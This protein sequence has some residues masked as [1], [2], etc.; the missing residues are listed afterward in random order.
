MPTL[1]IVAGVVGIFILLILIAIHLYV[2]VKPNQAHVIV[3]A[4][5]RRVYSPSSIAMGTG[6]KKSYPTSYFFIPFLM[7][8]II[9]SLENVKHEINQVELRDTN[10]APFKCDITC[11]FKIANPD[12]AAEKLDVDAQGNI[13]ESIRQTLDASVMGITRAAAMGQEVIALM[14]DRKTFG[15]KVFTEVNGDLDEWGVQLVKLE[16]IDFSDAS[17]SQVIKDHEAR[18][19]AEIASTTRQEVAEQTKKAE[20]VEAEARKVAE[21]AKLASKEDIEMREIKKNESVGIRKE[22]SRLKIEEQTDKANA[23]KVA[24]DRTLMVGEAEYQADALEIVAEGKAK[25]LIK[26]AHGNKEARITTAT[27]EANAV[28]LNADA[29]AEAV[30]KNGNAEASVHETKGTADAEVIRQRGLATAEALEKKADAQKKFTEAS[31]EIEFKKIDAEV[32]IAKYASQAEAYKN[33]DIQIVSDD[34][35]FLGFDA[36]SGVGLGLALDN[37]KKTSKLD[38]S[39]AVSNIATVATELLGKKGK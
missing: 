6:E 39:K 3:D 11:W 18:R 15:E 33:A 27:G 19:E 7:E 34:M 8:R 13:M 35:N 31:Q 10:V 4:R 21:T 25:A 29:Q 9:V 1:F 12:L 14:R 24:A 16:I 20:V 32:E 5:G 28:K 17:N 22:A 26:Q 2:V 38:V 23:K 30:T 36:K 37:V